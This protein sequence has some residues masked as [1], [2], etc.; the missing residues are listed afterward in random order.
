MALIS[1]AVIAQVNKDIGEHC[2]RRHDYNKATNY[3]KLSL[4]SQTDKMDTIARMAN[5]Q[6]KNADLQEALKNLQENST[7]DKYKKS[8]Q[9]NLQECDCF[10]DMNAFEDNVKHISEKATKLMSRVEHIPFCGPILAER[11][12]ECKRKG[13]KMMALKSRFNTVIT[14]FEDMIGKNAGNCLYDQRRNFDKITQSPIHQKKLNNKQENKECDVV[15]IR[16]E[17]TAKKSV[18]ENHRIELLN[19][20]FAQVYMQSAWKDFVFINTLKANNVL[21]QSNQNKESFDII[22]DSIDDCVD[23]TNILIEQC[24]A[25]CPLYTYN[26]KMFFNVHYKEKSQRTNLMRVKYRTCR[27]MFIALDK[28]TKL[29][30]MGKLKNLI[31]VAE[32][33]LGTHYQIKSDKVMPRKTEFVQ[34]ICNIIGLAHVDKLKWS[35]S[36]VYI[37][38]I[39]LL[40]KI[41]NVN[42]QDKNLSVPYKFGDQSTYRDPGEPDTSFLIFKQNINRLE[43]RLK[44]SRM[45]LERSHLYHELGKQNL[46]QS[47]YDEVRNFAKKVIAESKNCS[48]LWEFLGVILVCRADIMQQNITKFVDSVAIAI[49]IAE[50]FNNESLNEILEI[51]QKTALKI[52]E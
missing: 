12:V 36:Y 33:E 35:S 18:K 7:S 2:K 46:T 6:C 11:M 27:E 20:K 25:R 42:I 22:N 50:E 17:A 13:P 28:L 5:T 41:F 30:K 1:D 34:E 14:N 45:P 9:C 26:T 3:F 23:K 15:S 8:F 10:Y 19:R 44:N 38:H 16:E 51:A 43:E 48:R 32:Y 21:S 49:D 40:A 29:R 24:H 37:M 52:I 47:K 31:E 39:E 4:Q